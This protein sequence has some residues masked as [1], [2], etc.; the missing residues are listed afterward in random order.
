MHKDIHKA[1]QRHKKER[2]NIPGCNH[3][4]WE[5]DLHNPKVGYSC[6]DHVPQSKN[7]TRF[8]RQC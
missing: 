2:G 1:L 4:W 7:E 6:D 3:S 8:V 5:R